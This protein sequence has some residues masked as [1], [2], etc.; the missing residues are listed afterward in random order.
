MFEAADILEAVLP[1]VRGV[2]DTLAIHPERMRAAIDDTLL[3]T[4][5]ADYLVRKGIP[6]R[7]AHTAAGKAVRRSIELGV[8]LSRMESKE[9]QAVHAAF[10]K[11]IADVFDVES[12]LAR[13]NTKGGTAPTAVQEQIESARR[14]LAGK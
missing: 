11:D 12:V 3:A 14:K 6:F 2:I 13:R 4:D 7:Q 10:D 5:L 8:S 9:Y 1:V